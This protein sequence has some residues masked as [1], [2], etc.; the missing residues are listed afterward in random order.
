V[1]AGIAPLK[2][3]RCCLGPVNVS[4]SSLLPAADIAAFGCGGRD[5]CRRT[6]ATNSFITICF[7]QPTGGHIT[8]WQNAGN[9]GWF[10]AIAWRLALSRRTPLNLYW[11]CQPR[12]RRA[13]RDAYVLLLPSLPGYHASAGKPLHL[14]L[15]APPLPGA[16]SLTIASELTCRS[17]L[18]GALWPFNVTGMLRRVLQ[19]GGRRRLGCGKWRISGWNG[20]ST[21][22]A[23][24][25][26]RVR[27]RYLEWAKQHLR[28]CALLCAPWRRRVRGALHVTPSILKRAAWRVTYGLAVQ[29][30]AFPSPS[31][32]WRRGNGSSSLAQH[33]R[34]TALGGRQR[35]PLYRLAVWWQAGGA[36]AAR[37]G[38]WCARNTGVERWRRRWER[39]IRSA[40]VLPLCA[41]VAWLYD[42]CACD[43][44]F[45][46]ILASRVPYQKATTLRPAIS[47][48]AAVPSLSGA[49]SRV[50]ANAPR[51][52]VPHNAALCAF[53]SY[54]TEGT[55]TV[56]PA[57]HAA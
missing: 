32:Q 12:R 3:S 36:T 9:V 39:V 30:G 23:R 6:A 17:H 20:S 26:W 53:G 35:C 21:G 45:A 46:P 55:R 29:A 22:Q 43:N 24:F 40:S 13:S 5:A 37:G 42:G 47:H 4:I 14:L 56:L 49:T 7:L 51:T 18:A 38:R 44:G 54:G 19:A 2:T 25:A 52:S 15:F 1:C 31:K 57:R 33:R 41:A 8:L 27:C 50:N 16:L 10:F 34:V 48:L 28:T 11:Y